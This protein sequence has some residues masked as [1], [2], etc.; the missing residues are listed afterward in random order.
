MPWSTLSSLASSTCPS[1]L[2]HILLLT[3]KMRNHYT[4][5]THLKTWLCTQRTGLTYEMPLIVCN[6]YQTRDGDSKL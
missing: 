6:T 5:Y 2:S 3:S 4:F 1:L